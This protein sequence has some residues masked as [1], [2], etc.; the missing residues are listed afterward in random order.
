MPKTI[1]VPPG[2]IKLTAYD[3]DRYILVRPPFIA[4]I[5][6]LPVSMSALS[7]IEY[8]QRTRIDFAN[9]GYTLVEET[10]AQIAE[11]IGKV[12]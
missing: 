2:F 5:V 6:E 12:Q 9:G 7:D 3:E 11:L 4:A 1:H 10:A 8:R